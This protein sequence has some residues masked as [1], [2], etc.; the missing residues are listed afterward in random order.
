MSGTATDDGVPAGGGLAIT[1]VKVSGPGTV[2]FADPTK[3]STT[4]TFSIDGTYNLRLT[5]SDTQ[6][7]TN[8]EVKIVVNPGNQAPVV[9]AGADQ[10]VT[11]NAAT[12]S[13]TATDDGRPNGTLTISWSKFS[14]PGT[15][16]FSSPAALTTSASGRT[17]FD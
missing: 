16:S 2:T 3:L 1:W 9:N 6:L 17:S 8:D 11:T 5:A 12:L 10:T 13:G 15:V 4:A 7:T 14:G